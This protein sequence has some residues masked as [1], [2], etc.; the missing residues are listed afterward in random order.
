M[1]ETMVGRA[2]SVSQQQISK[3][4]RGISQVAVSQLKLLA[5]LY[6]TTLVEILTEMGLDDTRRHS[7]AEPEA[8]LFAMESSEPMIIDL[9]ALTDPSD[10]QHLL[11]HY[12][13]LKRRS[14]RSSLTPLDGPDG[15][16][17]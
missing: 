15:K 4:E 3:Q 7:F 11:R 5:G 14:A 2:I 8:A 12:N 6:G 16:E 10:R 13:A 1:T 17:T 9:A